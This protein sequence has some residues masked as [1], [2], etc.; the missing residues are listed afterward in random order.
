MVKL[1]LLD[2]WL[3][4][5]DKLIKVY[6]D[7]YSPRDL[8][9]CPLCVVHRVERSIQEDDISGIRMRECYCPWFVFKDWQAKAE[10]GCYCYA[11]VQTKEERIARLR[12]WKSRIL[13]MKRR[14]KK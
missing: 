12:D 4:A 11:C 2:D 1:T 3:K 9:D 6:G 13:R 14:R 5:I 7:G 10:A 8:G